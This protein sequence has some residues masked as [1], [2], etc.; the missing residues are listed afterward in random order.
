MCAYSWKFLAL[1]SQ[2]DPLFAL[3]GL[4]WQFFDPLLVFPP[5]FLTLFDLYLEL[6][7]TFCNLRGGGA[8][9]AVK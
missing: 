3:C 6:F 5:N 9:W 7:V 8:Q 4:F 1:L 2:F